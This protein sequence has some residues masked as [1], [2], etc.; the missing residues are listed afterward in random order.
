MSPGTD[1]KIKK[2][3]SNVAFV[4]AAPATHLVEH[5]ESYDHGNM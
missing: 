4:Y 1:M 3:E 2:R 5:N